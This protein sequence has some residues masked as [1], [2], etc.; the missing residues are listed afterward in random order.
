MTTHSISYFKTH[1]LQILNNFEKQKGELII[2]KR[3]KPLAKVIPYSEKSNLINQ[4]GRLKDTV[5][6]EGDILTAFGEDEWE[7]KL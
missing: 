2:T 6:S 3:G 5:I 1:L 4:P 7:L